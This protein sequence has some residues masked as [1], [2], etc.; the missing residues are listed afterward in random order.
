M[1]RKGIKDMMGKL[2]YRTSHLQES[3]IEKSVPGS[4]SG[5]SGIQNVYNLIDGKVMPKDGHVFI[6]LSEFLQCNLRIILLR[7]TKKEEEETQ[8]EGKE[9]NW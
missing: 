4:W 8:H 9:I 5:K 6:F 2:R 7:Y 3:L 1:E